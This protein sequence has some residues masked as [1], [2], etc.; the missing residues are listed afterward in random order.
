MEMNIEV[1][2]R[3]PILI[4]EDNLINQKVIQR[5][6]QKLGYA[7]DLVANGQEVIDALSRL[8]YALIFMDCQMPEIDGF[9]ACREIRK[10]EVGGPRVPI[11]AITANAMKGDRERCLAAG[12]DDYVSKPF[13][14]DDLRA[15]IDR[16]IG[17]APAVSQS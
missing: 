15:V 4:A 2:A 3:S 10:R 9:E 13:K 7:V 8:S 11:V 17:S 16:W 5:M 12:M 6:V 1:G 14:Q